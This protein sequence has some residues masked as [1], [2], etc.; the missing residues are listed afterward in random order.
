ML[1]SVALGGGEHRL[2]SGWLTWEWARKKIGRV[3]RE[4]ASEMRSC[5]RCWVV[6]SGWPRTTVGVWLGFLETQSVL[7]RGL[8]RMPR[9][10]LSELWLNLSQEPWV[11]SRSMTEEEDSSLTYLPQIWYNSQL[12]WLGSTDSRYHLPVLETKLGRAERWLLLL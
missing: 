11:P 9:F 1:V 3:K 10:L 4:Q 8:G 2:N 7:E 5:R 6:H 12:L